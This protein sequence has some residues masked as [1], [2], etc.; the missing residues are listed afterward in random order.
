MSNFNEKLKK[1]IFGLFLGKNGS[2]TYIFR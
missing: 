2:L 1:L